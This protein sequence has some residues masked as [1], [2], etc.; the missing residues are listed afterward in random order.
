[1]AIILPPSGFSIRARVRYR[2]PLEEYL[3][4]GEEVLFRSSS[5]VKYGAKPYR[6]VVT[7]RRVVLYASRGAVFK[8]DDV[9]AQKMEELTGVKYSERGVIGKKG[10]ITIESRTRMDL[11]GPAGEMKA[12]YQQMMR[13]M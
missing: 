12:L 5:A 7:D 8:S 10:I 1:M 11:V 6:V 4:P 13:F 9:V 2:L 3:M